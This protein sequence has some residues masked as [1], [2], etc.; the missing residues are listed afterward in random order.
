VG[1]WHAHCHM[2]SKL[3]TKP[4][5]FHQNDTHIPL[6][7]FPFQIT[8]PNDMAQSNKTPSGTPVNK[9]NFQ[10]H[11][12]PSKFP[13]FNSHSHLSLSLTHT[14]FISQNNQISVFISLFHSFLETLSS[15]VRVF[16]FRING[17][18][19]KKIS[20]RRWRTRSNFITLHFSRYTHYNYYRFFVLISFLSSDSC[21]LFTE[22]IRRKGKRKLA[23]TV[24]DDGNVMN[25]DFIH[26]SYFEVAQWRVHLVLVSIFLASSYYCMCWCLIWTVFLWFLK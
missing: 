23:S 8:S 15:R 14:L 12:R 13:P 7:H 17:T 16:H 1:A 19:T 6:S 24:D 20:S 22:K 11:D 18:S 5:L 9:Q 4:Q 2:C 25:L 3:D 10:G 26:Y 21:F